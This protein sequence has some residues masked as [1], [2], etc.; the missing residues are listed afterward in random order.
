MRRRERRRS[1]SEIHSK[2]HT[3]SRSQ[4][5]NSRRQMSAFDDWT[6]RFIRFIEEQNLPASQIW[7]DVGDIVVLGKTLCV[8]KVPSNDRLQSARE[9][10]DVAMSRGVGVSLE[11]ICVADDS[12]CC[13]VYV[14]H[15]ESE[16]EYRM[17]PDK[18]A[19]MSA[20]ANPLKTKLVNNRFSWWLI[21]LLGRD[22]LELCYGPD[23][24]DSTVPRAV[25]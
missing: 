21:K 7:V 6:A 20:P 10:F 5:S 15:S 24:Q 3:A 14:P 8:R 19:K 2:C 25:C 22:Y 13:F 16:A 4:S 1:R 9:R 11:A 17:V 12:T 23:P 18:G